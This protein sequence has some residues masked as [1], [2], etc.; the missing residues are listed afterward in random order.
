MASGQ[1]L[2]ELRRVIRH[3]ERRSRPLAKPEAIEKILGG[4]VIANDDGALAVFRHDYALDH[5][6]GRGGLGSAT[7]VPPDLVRVLAR[8]DGALPDPRRFVFLDTETTGLA[9]GTGTYAFLVGAG[10]VEDDRFVV[11]QYFM[12][13]LDE[14]AALLTALVPLLERASAIVSF[15]GSGF[16][17]PLLETRFV[18]ARR[19]WP[20]ALSHVDLLRPARRVWGH[21]LDDCRLSTLERTVLGVERGD[22]V[23]GAFIPSI[24]FT[25]LRSR[26][27]APLA[28]VLAHNRDDVLSLAALLGWLVE[29][30]GRRR[31]TASE[32]AGLGALWDGV[33]V[34]RSLEHYRLALAAGLSGLAAHRVR[35]RLATWEKRRERWEDACS[36]WELAAAADVFDH[37]PWEEL[38]KF[39]EHR[40]RDAAEARVIVTRALTL[41]LAARASSGV[42]ERLRYRLG[43]LERRLSR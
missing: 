42:V 41:A 19:R 13:D 15:N 25:F 3:I 9:G 31:L 43:R 39:H 35:L 33:D 12:R 26:Q 20:T 30:H 17:V 23:P 14:E 7:A 29:A 5:R 2:D 28:R 36:L 11:V 38:A 21:A 37:R 16:D 6:H 18:L 10:Y 27:P 40:R 34:E 1:T 8:G 4:E 32:L 22:D 24:Y